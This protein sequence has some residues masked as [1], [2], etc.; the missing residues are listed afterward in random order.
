MLIAIHFVLLCYEVL[1]R[2]LGVFT[3]LPENIL[4]HSKTKRMII[5]KLSKM[6]IYIKKPVTSKV[7]GAKPETKESMVRRL[8]TKHKWPLNDYEGLEKAPKIVLQ[9]LLGEFN[10]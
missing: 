4:P 8:E 3:S 1:S 2:L 9:K 10:P 5:A 6:E 7:T